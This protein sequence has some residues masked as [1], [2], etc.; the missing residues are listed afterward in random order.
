MAIFTKLFG[1]GNTTFRGKKKEFDQVD[2]DGDISEY[3]FTQSSNGSVTVQHPEYGTD[4]LISIEGL[5]FI[6]SSTFYT[7]EEALT[8]SSEPIPVEP[9]S[10]E[11]IEPEPVDPKPVDPTPSDPYIIGTDGN[12]DLIGS[13]INNTF[14]TGRGDDFVHGN[15]GVYNQVDLEGS[16][17]DYVFVQNANGSVSAS[18][19][20]NST[21]TMVDIDGVWF[22]GEAQWYSL[23]D[24]IT[25]AGVEP[26][27]P[28]PV[29]PEPVD[30]EP[31]DPFIQGTDG[32]DTLIGA[33]MNNTFFGGLGDDVI[34]GNGGDYNQ[35]DYEGS[36]ME[37]AMTQND[38]GS[39][40]VT[41]PIWGTD[42]L[43]DI[44]GFWFG[45]DAQWYSLAD[46]L[47]AVS[48]TEPVNPEPVDP[49]PV[50]PEPVNPE[51]VDPGP[52]GPSGGTFIDGVYTGTSGVDALV[53]GTDAMT[54][55]TGM[56]VGDT[57]IG[58]SNADTLNVEGG[59]VEWTF[60]NNADGSVTMTHPTWGS[61]TMTGIDSI[62]FGRT[63][64]TLSVADAA[65][66]TAGLPAFRLDDDGVVNGTPFD[67][68]MVGTDG[69][70]NYYGGVGNDVYDGGAGF[71]QVNYDGLR[72]DYT[73]VDNGDGTINISN[74]V[75]GTDTL[76]SI[77]GIFF[78]GGSNGI[79]VDGITVGQPEFI[80]VTDLFGAA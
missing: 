49:E 14:S 73:I 42:T 1:S 72:S 32:N 67:D 16:I 44:D 64:Q 78:N 60:F 50:D 69:F 20:D 62:L 2:Y 66:A 7:I 5:W 80:L 46:A 75:F 48:G 37:Y 22:I 68:V 58:N 8:L 19:A 52:A 71:D 63:G 61:N 17:A 65:A 10:P 13:D 12:D 39:I 4:T 21:V 26:V 41:H 54:F 70:D 77:E 35:A 57:V 31:V 30:P 45:G 53:G 47:A 59:V 56:G 34:D 24:A 55:N 28:E 23:T 33:E 40:T 74:D 27:D 6:G 9:V 18:R 25:I 43:T 36:I 38:D 76:S 11:P 51:P 15:G 29:E 3:T 79:P